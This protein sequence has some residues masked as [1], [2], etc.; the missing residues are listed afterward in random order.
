[1]AGR[2]SIRPLAP[3]ENKT[4]NWHPTAG[5]DWWRRWPNANIGV[6][7][8]A[9]LFVIDVDRDAILPAAKGAL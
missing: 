4:R 9:G 2:K 5:E 8:G 3:N 6:A 7:T 1:L